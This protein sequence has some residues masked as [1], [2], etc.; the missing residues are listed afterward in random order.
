MLKRIALGLFVIAVCT[1]FADAQAAVDHD[2]NASWND[3]QVTVPM[4]KYFDFFLSGTL[5]FGKNITRVQETRVGVGFVFKPFKDWSFSPS[6][7]N[8]NARNSSG[9]FRREN[10]LSFYARYRLPIKSFGLIHKSLF[11]WRIRRPRESW[12]YRP[13]LTFEKDL[14]KDFFIKKAKFY[15]TEEVF[16]DSALDKWSRNRFTVGITKTLNKKTS[17]DIYYMRQ[18]DGFSIPGDLNVIGTS[19]KIKL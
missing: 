2:D 6:Y 1:V 15:V 17:V 18:N 16:Y 9:R 11:E 5:R 13:S 12:R 4:D 3:V 7:L 14:P 19:W 10:R 8:I